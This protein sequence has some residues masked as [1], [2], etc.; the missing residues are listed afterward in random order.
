[1]RGPRTV[2]WCCK[3]IRDQD[4]GPRSRHTKWRSEV[5]LERTDQAVQDHEFC[6]RVLQTAVQY[7]QLNVSELASMELVMRR[8]QV[9]EFR[10]RERLFGRAGGGDELLEDEHLYMGTG[11]TKGLLM[12]SPALSEYIADELHKESTVLKERRKI[13]EER[14]AGRHP[15]GKGRGHEGDG[16]G[17]PNAALQ[18]KCDKQAAEIKRLKGQLGTE[19]GDAAD[20]SGGKRG[21]GRGRGPG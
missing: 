8:A 3:F 15:P 20:E 5:G 12:V 2:M 10:H 14:Q 11:E 17:A 4:A 1:M 19:P 18:S 9:A 13:R 16:G 7:D 21:R 6:M